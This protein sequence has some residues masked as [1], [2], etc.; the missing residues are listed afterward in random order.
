MTKGLFVTFEGLDGSGKTTQMRLLANHLRAH[1]DTVIETAE[2]GGTRAGGGIRSILL[3]P[4]NHNL[5]AT[6]E[7]LLYFAARAQNVDEILTP[8]I[9]AGH[10]VLC[11]RWTDSTFAYQGFGRR[12][13]EEIVNQ[14]DAIACRGRKPDLTIWIDIDL[15]T[16][17]HR[18]ATRNREMDSA[19]TR[20]DEQERSFYARV[21]DGYR[22]LS[23]LEPAR[24]RR[25][26]GSGSV[27]DVFQR[28]LDLFQTFRSEHVR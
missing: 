26:D 14:L 2:P 21:L 17:L 3:D 27:E 16:G 13:G 24:F 23:S 11:D 10:V 18:A 28:V 1:G 12:L 7:L 19:E 9:A 15:E 20:M 8:A 22:R 6:A 25:V 4:A 5:G